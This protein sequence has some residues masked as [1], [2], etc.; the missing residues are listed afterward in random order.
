LHDEPFPYMVPVN[1]GYADGRLYFHSAP[2]GKKIDLIKRNNRVCFETESDF[3]LI[4]GDTPCH[5]SARYASVIGFGRAHLIEDPEGKRKGL[6]VILR[7]YSV[8][9]LEI[10]DTSL[11]RI[12]VIGIEVESMTGKVSPKPEEAAENLVDS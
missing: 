5:W 7:H 1:F 11:A 12:V 6:E 9:T 4:R 3:G 8:D 2:E 10:P